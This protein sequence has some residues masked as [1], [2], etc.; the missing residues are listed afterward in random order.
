MKLYTFNEETR[1]YIGCEKQYIDP[2]ESEKAGK[3]VYIK[4]TNGTK[5]KPL[6][7]SENE[8]NVFIK[9]KWE[10]I[11]DFRTTRAFYK[12][13]AKEVVFN[14]GDN[15]TENMTTLN[16]LHFTK[17]KWDNDKNVWNDEANKDEIIADLRERIKEKSNNQ[18]G[19]QYANI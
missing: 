18:K 5:K 17:P 6:K 12:K 2:L 11:V 10:L 8:A 3:N 1:E 13:D 14:L 15:F 7:V 16:P 9:N 19:E 4:I